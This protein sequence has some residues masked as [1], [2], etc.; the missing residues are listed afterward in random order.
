MIPAVGCLPR[1]GSTLITALLRQ[2]PS[3]TVTPTGWLVS[4]VGALSGA[5]TQ[6]PARTSW[7]D[8]HDARARL[9][10]AVRG[11]CDGYL[12]AGGGALNVEKGR[13]LLHWFETIADAYGEPPRLVLPVRDLRGVMA[14]MERLYRANPQAAGYAA[15]EPT[16][17][18]RVQAWAGAN[19]APVGRAVAELADAMQRGVVGNCLV[20]RYEDLTR[21]PLGQLARVYGF[22]GYELPPGVHDPNCVDEPNREHDAVHGPFGDHTIPA[23]PVRPAQPNWDQVLGPELSRDIVAGNQWFY[24]AFYPDVLETENEG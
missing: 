20:V 9:R 22:W 23:G 18:R 19:A 11:A 7:L 1:A 13:G 10:A 4:L 12:S 21:D 6:N 17:Q 3:V 15:N 5:Y 2:N 8:Q 24:R 14:S 16:V